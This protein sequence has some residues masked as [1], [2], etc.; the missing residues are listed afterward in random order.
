MTRRTA[1]G[2]AAA[3]SSVISLAGASAQPL[4]LGSATAQDP[5]SPSFRYGSKEEAA[6]LD[7][8]SRVEWKLAAQGGLILTTGNSRVTTFAAG[9]SASR[10]ANRNKFSLEAGAAYARS[11]IDLAI[12]QNNSGRIDPSEIIERSQT[13]TRSW[14]VKARYDRFVTGADA[15][16]GAA[17][18]SADRPAGKVLV[19]N[20]QIG[21]SRQ[22]LAGPVHA[23]VAEAGYD[24]TY[25]DLVAGDG[26]A[27]HSLRAFAGYTVKPSATSAIDVSV[28]ALSNLNELR[29]A[30]GA[31]S[32]FEDNRVNGKLSVTTVLFRDISFRV[33][34]EARYD[35]APAPRPPLGL[36]Y[37]DG[38]VPLAETLD[39][40]TEATLIVSFL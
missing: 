38:F 15:V 39:T 32:S 21:Y 18:M 34:F 22:L 40:R 31:I 23:L 13:T 10:K 12:D 4:P 8:A 16:Y 9:A 29:S 33:G 2:L 28:E 30:G 25:E 20:G 3:L 37:A 11:R 27:I 19:G 5:A 26:V 1:R 35:N 24:L 7:K 6:E 14:L 36:D 17:G